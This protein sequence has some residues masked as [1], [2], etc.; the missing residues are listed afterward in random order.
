MAK[1]GTEKL[2]QISITLPPEVRAFHE[3]AAERDSR[4]L[5]GQIRHLCVE[6]ARRNGAA[7]GTPW[8]PPLPNVD[9]TRESIDAAKIQLAEWTREHDRLVA[10]ERAEGWRFC[11]Q[12]MDRKCWLQETIATFTP[13]IEIAERMMDRSAA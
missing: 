8:P 13:R 9:S 10:K 3:R 2:E 7:N 1:R 5:S 12:D 4:S 11:G 6:A